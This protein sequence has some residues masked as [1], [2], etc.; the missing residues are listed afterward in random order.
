RQLVSQ[1]R[2]EP[3]LRSSAPSSCLLLAKLLALEKIGLYGRNTT[4]EADHYIGAIAKPSRI[5]A[6]SP[7]SNSK[8]PTYSLF[9][10]IRGLQR[11]EEEQKYYRE[12]KPDMGRYL[13]EQRNSNRYQKAKKRWNS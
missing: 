9:P 13:F 10:F 7:S 12:G 8:R 5:K 1:V 6:S 3:C 2:N 4:F 11:T